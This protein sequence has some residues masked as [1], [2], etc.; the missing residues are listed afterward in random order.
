VR[1][2]HFEKRFSKFLWKSHKMRFSHYVSNSQV[3]NSQI[4]TDKWRFSDYISLSTFFPPFNEHFQRKSHKKI[5]YS[6]KEPYKKILYSAKETYTF[7]ALTHCCQ[8]IVRKSRKISHFSI[9]HALFMR[10][11]LIWYIVGIWYILRFSHDGVATL[12]GSLKL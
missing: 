5:L 10:F 7:K 8:L 1:K 4:L 11:A 12:V 3:S 2:S 6:A 9:Q